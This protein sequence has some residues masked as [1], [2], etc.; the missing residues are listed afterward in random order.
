M[1]T[2][3][4]GWL[5]VG[6]LLAAVSL[7]A[8]TP[9]NTGP[10]KFTDPGTI[11]VAA[12][13]GEVN[14][15]VS[16]VTTRLEVNK[17]VPQKAKIVTG[18]GA[19]VVLVFSNGA[20]TQL[21]SDTELVIDEY[22]QDPFAATVKVAEMVDEPSPSR[23]KLSLNRGEIVGNVKK[24]K[25]D[26]GST[27][28]VQTPVG[29]AGIRGTTFRIVFRPSGTGQ[30]FFT[31]STAI[32][33]V[34]FIPPGSTSGTQQPNAP[35]TPAVTGSGTANL[36]VPP[37]QEIS[38]IVDVTIN[39]QGQMV[40]TVVPTPTSTTAITPANLQAVTQVA[41][42]IAV[43]VQQTVFT[44]A[45]PSGGGTGTGGESGGTTGSTTGST[46]GTG[47]SGSVTQTITGPNFEGQVTTPP[48]PGNTAVRPSTIT[49]TP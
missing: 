42:D 22:L 12:V 4:L 2:R 1:Q 25:Y 36:Q 9:I 26:R 29:A 13:N 28:D 41:A 8:Q 31:L 37:G 49:T 19:R 44:S 6:M 46:T 38:M 39:A 18:K 33:Q 7:R 32:G 3:L 47:N 11:L 5:F 14:M 17:P 48:P 21:G 30:A 24:L 10:G 43:A 40:V 34:D 45:P 23:T 15:I 16:G 27:F 20:S 35:G